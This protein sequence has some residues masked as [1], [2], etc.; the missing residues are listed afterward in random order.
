MSFVTAI[1]WSAHAFGLGADL[2]AKVTVLLGV[3]LA[4]SAGLARWRASLGSAVA[5]A[6]LLGLLLVSLLGFAPS[7]DRARMASGRIE[8]IRP[9]VRALPAANRRAVDRDGDASVDARGVDR[10]PTTLMT[11]HG[12]SPA[13]TASVPASSH[14]IVPAPSSLV[15]S[16]PSRRIDWLLIGMAGYAAVAGVLLVRLLASLAAV[17]RLRHSSPHVADGPWW[18]ALERCR[19]RLGIDRP[20]GL[21]WSPRVGVPVV[22]GWI[23]PTIV[24]RRHCRESART[25]MPMPSCST[26]C[27]TCCGPTIRGT[28]SRS[29]FRPFT[30]RT[31]SSGFWV[32]PW[33]KCANVPV[34]NCVFTSWAVRRDIGRLCWPW[35]R[36][37]RVG[38]ALRS[39]WRWRVARGSVSGWHASSRARVRLSACR[40]YV[41]RLTI[42]GTA[43][44]LRWLADDPSSRGPRRRAVAAVV[45][46]PRCRRPKVPQPQAGGGPGVPLARRRGRYGKA[47]AKRRRP[48]LDRVSR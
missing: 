26:S 25:V 46:S 4:R 5:N 2:A 15:V 14:A 42:C 47:G 3:G 41:H 20:V 17:A 35:P 1:P 28:C 40:L 36:G 24:C 8:W 44:G 31:R 38:R 7:R 32:G 6:C 11:G 43:V 30:G 48:P 22:L 23:R 27:R 21:A 9:R 45:R 12:S 18:L 10:N 29:S 39:A 37:S 33:P 13:S 34:T 19:R 16:P